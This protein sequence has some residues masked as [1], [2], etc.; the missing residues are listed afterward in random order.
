M[1]IKVRRICMWSG[2]QNL[3]T[4]MMRAWGN[5]DDTAVWDEPFY[6]HYL[7]STGV[8][9]PGA[10]EVIR[11]HETDWRKVVSRLQGPIPPG[12]SI[13][14]QKHMAHHLL[15]H[16]DRSWLEHADHVFLIR[17]P[18]EM[19]VFLQRFVPNLR[20]EDTGLI[21]QCEL[22]RTLAEQYGRKPLVLDAI[23]VLENPREMLQ[24]LCHKLDLPFTEEMLSWQPGTRESDGIWGKYWYGAV[25][26]ATTFET[27]R[28]PSTSVPRTMLPLLYRAQEL[29]DQLHP[30]RLQVIDHS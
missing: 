18:Y 24:L 26:Q 23:D 17:D 30:H 13:L 15:P 28:P 29:Y 7:L 25:C 20:L 2:T 16:I 10:E 1:S 11:Y 12:K 4:A 9:H 3:A 8:I 14:Y 22:F 21:H 5:R 27:Y 6:A 19:F